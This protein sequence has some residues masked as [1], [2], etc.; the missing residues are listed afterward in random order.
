M[1]TA[2][3]SPL[4]SKLLLELSGNVMGSAEFCKAVCE[5]GGNVN[6]WMVDFVKFGRSKDE[7][8]KDL[9]TRFRKFCSIK[10]RR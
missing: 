7:I 4:L 2:V 5:N 10:F 1:T 8:K 9:E 6:F 3:G